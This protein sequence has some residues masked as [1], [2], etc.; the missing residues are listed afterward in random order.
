MKLDAGR[1]RKLD[2]IQRDTADDAAAEK[3]GIS[4]VRRPGDRKPDAACAVV[5]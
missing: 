4:G 1:N 3:S 5:D 2:L